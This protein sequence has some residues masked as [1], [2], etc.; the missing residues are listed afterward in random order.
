MFEAF[1]NAVVVGPDVVLK[2]GSNDHVYVLAP[3]AVSI[4]DDPEHTAVPVDAET[5]T[6][7]A[8]CTTMG[9]LA[10][11]VPHAFVTSTVTL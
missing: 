8:S 10:M 3:E 5:L 6:T 9:V 11:L 7:G 1:G 2:S 4:V